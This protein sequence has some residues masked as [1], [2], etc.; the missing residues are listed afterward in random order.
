MKTMVGTS[1][2]M[3]PEVLN[4][5][6][7]YNNKCDV[8]SLGVIM[9]MM[10]TGMPPFGGNGE[11]DIMR[12]VAN[13]D[14]AFYEEDWVDM[15]DAAKLVKNMLVVDP[16]K[17]FS[18]QQ[19]LASDWMKNNQSDGV[20]QMISADVIKS[21]TK[22]A[23]MEQLKKTAVQVVAFTLPPDEINK[24]RDQ[25]KAFDEDGSGTLSLAEFRGAMEKHAGMDSTSIAELFSKIDSDHTGLISYSEFI[26]ASL[27]TSV[28]L[29]EDRLC[30][31]FDKLDPDKSGY[32]DAHELRN[33]LKGTVQESDIEKMIADA[34]EEG[35]HDGKISRDEFIK[36]VQHD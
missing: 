24:L 26:S 17:R 29:N 32:I 16:A 35:E 25:F 3:A 18:C 8:W 33:L 2:Y 31:A 14:I 19:V 28:H 6:V 21:M 22:Y 36:L 5:Y 34:D 13:N 15:P 27:S 30:A 1:Y 12:A 23:H 11:T 4:E 20:Q 9:F 7:N 10:L